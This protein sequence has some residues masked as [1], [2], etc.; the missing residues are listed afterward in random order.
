MTKL[1]E[2][3]A[4]RP[5]PSGDGDPR[6][7]GSSDPDKQDD[8]AP[9]ESEADV[10]ARIGE[11]CEALRNLI[12][13]AGSKVA[14]LEE[15][16]QTFVN[17]VDP[18][19]QAL[20]ILEQE[21]TRNISLTRRLGQ[22]RTSYDTMQV[23]FDEIEKKNEA[24][25]GEKEQLR[26]ELEEEQRAVRELRGVR[27]EL[28]NDVDVVRAMVINLEHQLAD[29]SARV[30]TLT[31]ENQRYR[32]HAIDSETKASGLE[33]ELA[34][35]RETLSILQGENQSLQ[36]SLNHAVTD[37]SKIRHRNSE[38]E[39]SLAAATAR[40][41][42]MEATLFGLESDRNALLKE[43]NELREHQ[44]NA[45]NQLQAQF[46]ALQARAGMAEKLL[47]NTRQLLA[48]RSEEARA[49]D[50]QVAEARRARDAAEVRLR[51]IE[52]LLQAHENQIRELERSRTVLTE[53][54]TS[55]ANSLKSR[56][57]RL[58]EAEEQKLTAADQIARLEQDMKVGRMASEKRMDELLALLDHERLERQVVEGALD[59]TRAERAQLQHELYKLRR[60]VRRSEVPEEVPPPPA[61]P[62]DRDEEDQ[63]VRAADRPAA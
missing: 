15:T 61:P 17:I 6:E 32:S 47:G 5:L 62:R 28:S 37:A 54:N 34:A 7:L 42:Q 20:R 8:A 14:E 2:L 48:T 25:S 59:A 19:D 11:A 24:L 60:T 3:L 51:E 45:Q 50:R 40:I 23:K 12:V 27:V 63:S 53:R 52:A 57:G 55:L 13:E 1:S 43:V 41:Q 58:A 39:T 30:N 29:M 22:L 36:A 4:R 49:S 38:M 10:S 56:E 31:D 26:L 44:R 46:E 16:K 9:V 33:A 18:A 21:K 35:E